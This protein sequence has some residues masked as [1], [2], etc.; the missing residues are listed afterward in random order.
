[1]PCVIEVILFYYSRYIRSKGKIVLAVAASE[2]ASLLLTSGRTT[3]SR[4]KIPLD[5]SETC[6]CHIKKNTNLCELLKRTTAI[7]WD[8]AT[9]SD[10]RC[11]ECVDRTFRDILEKKGGSFRWNLNVVRG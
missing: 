10:K 3:H 11:F 5:L 8:E 9:M 6:V 1:M 4:F 2:I 7:V